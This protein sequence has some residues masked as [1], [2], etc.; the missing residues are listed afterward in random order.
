MEEN[1]IH[2]RTIAYE[3]YP[4]VLRPAEKGLRLANYLIDMLVFY[5]L[6]VLYGL[7]VGIIITIARGGDTSFID[8]LDNLNPLVDRLLTMIM[9]GCY[10][11]VTEGMF[12]GKSLGKL[13]TK[14]RA[15]NLDGSD[16]TFTTALKRGFSR[17]IPFEIFSTL[18]NSPWHDSLPGT[19]VVTEKERDI[20]REKQL[21]AGTT[22]DA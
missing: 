11:G 2:T 19:M 9:Y 8:E 21:L 15:V 1:N 3:L 4:P 5:C 6:I 13:I 16:I 14:T 7:L 10:M 12:Y 22:L 17:I 18:G 20:Y